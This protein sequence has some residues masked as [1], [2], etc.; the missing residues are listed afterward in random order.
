MILENTLRGRE[1]HVWVSVSDDLILDAQRDLEDIGG[2]FIKVRSILTTDISKKI[3]SKTTDF[4]RGCLFVTYSQLGLTKKKVGGGSTDKGGEGSGENSRKA[5]IVGWFK[6]GGGEGLLVFDEAHRY[7]CRL[8]LELNSSA[9]LRA[10]SSL[11]VSSSV[12]GEGG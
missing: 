5:Q 3:D 11:R 6:R 8:C 10:F 9:P 2:A 4:K 12:Q 7:R 1:R